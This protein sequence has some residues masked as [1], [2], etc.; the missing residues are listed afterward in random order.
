[1]NYEFL[2]SQTE[3]LGLNPERLFVTCFEGD[4]DAPRDE[5][6]AGIWREIFHKN[7]VKGERIYYRPADKNWWSVGENGPCGPDTEMFYDL[8]GEFSK[9]MSLA[10]YIQADEEQKVVEIWNDVF[11]EYLKKDGKVVGKLEQR[12][13]DTGSGLERI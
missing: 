2:T 4:D 5:E 9:G 1:M 11:M 3:G 8:T 13:V 12:N 7:N 6:S 10:E